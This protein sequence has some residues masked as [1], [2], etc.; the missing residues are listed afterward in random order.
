MMDLIDRQEVIQIRPEY[1]NE[2]VMRLS[3]VGTI[4]GR[5]YAKGWNTCLKRW[6][7]EIEQL[8]PVVQPEI[9]LGDAVRVIRDFLNECTGKTTWIGTPDGVILETDWGYVEEGLKLLEEY[10]ERQAI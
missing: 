3:Y 1:R 8:A 2:N 7:E 5:S 9:K 10:A 4:A 6:L